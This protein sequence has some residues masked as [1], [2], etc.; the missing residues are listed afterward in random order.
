MGAVCPDPD[1]PVSAKALMEHARS[2]ATQA[3][4]QNQQL[5]FKFSY[6][7]AEKEVIYH[8]LAQPILTTGTAAVL[9]MVRKSVFTACGNFRFRRD[10]QHG[11]HGVG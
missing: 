9:L 10:G 4:E 11:P 3:I 1:D 2:Y 5:S 8:G 6:R 7:S